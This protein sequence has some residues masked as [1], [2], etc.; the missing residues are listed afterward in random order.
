MLAH[1]VAQVL[2]RDGQFFGCL[3]GRSLASERGRG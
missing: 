3:A 1:D 2:E